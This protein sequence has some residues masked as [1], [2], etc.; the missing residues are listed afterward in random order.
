MP[1][2]LQ[3]MDLCR[4]FVGGNFLYNVGPRLGSESE[5]HLLH[6]GKLNCTVDL[7]FKGLRFNQTSKSVINSDANKAT[8][9]KLSDWRSGVQQ[10]AIE[11]IGTCYHAWQ[12]VPHNVGS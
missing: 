9:P 8:E 4:N 10:S 11:I 5:Y 1:C 7:S 3:K 2:S 6:K 12:L